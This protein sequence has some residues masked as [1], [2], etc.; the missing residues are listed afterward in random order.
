MNTGLYKLIL[1]HS[2]RRN[3]AGTEDVE[4]IQRRVSA[5]IYS[6]LGISEDTFALEQFQAMSKYWKNSEIF[7]KVKP[8]SE[9][10][11]P[12][13]GFYR[14]VYSYMQNYNEG[15]VA[16]ICGWSALVF[17]F[18]AAAS[19]SWTDAI[20]IV[21]L[22]CIELEIPQEDDHAGYFYKFIGMGTSTLQG[23][24]AG[25]LVSVMFFQW[26]W[27]VFIGLAQ[28]AIYALLWY[29][30]HGDGNIEI[31]HEAHLASV[32]QG[33]VA[34][35]GFR[36]FFRSTKRF[37]FFSKYSRVFTIFGIPLVFY[38]I[39]QIAGHFYDIK[40]VPRIP[41][42]VSVFDHFEQ[43]IRAE[44]AT[45]DVDVRRRMINTISKMPAFS[46]A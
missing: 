13:I 43:R 27:V 23:W 17:L 20:L 22:A 36:F 21:T 46:S 5:H 6:Q 9:G 14:H 28:V 34:G 12:I 2:V 39:E 1:P 40:N 35:L 10:P 8:E 33:L 4:E 16:T 7:G 31:E 45:E 29:V 38:G 42:W 18:L 24:L 32:I 11:G 30:D 15:T 3:L 37:E 25:Y 26:N 19:V 44:I 41:W